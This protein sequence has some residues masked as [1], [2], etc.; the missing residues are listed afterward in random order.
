M[1]WIVGGIAL[2]GSVSLV[3]M[4]FNHGAHRKPDPDEFRRIRSLS[5][6]G[7]R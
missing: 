2:W 1:I 5:V 7:E 4:A 6:R 3:A